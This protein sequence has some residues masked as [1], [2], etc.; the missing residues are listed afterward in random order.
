V[1]YDTL[2]FSNT[3]KG[4]L[5]VAPD[6]IVGRQR[7][8]DAVKR[9]LDDASLP[10]TLLIEGEAGIGKTTIWTEAARLAGADGRL[11]TARPSESE[12]KLSFSVLTD[13][14]APTLSEIRDALPVPQLRA[15]EL[16]LLLKAP[17]AGARLDARA[18]S[19]GTLGA[20]R[21]LA[22]RMPV[23]IAIDDVHW[24]DAASARSL[25]FA[26]R[27]LVNE[28]ITVVAARRVPGPREP[29]GLT[30]MATLRGL[31]LGPLPVDA[32]A[33]S[34][35]HVDGQFPR[36]LAKRI[37]EASGGNPFYALEIGRA[38]TRSSSSQPRAGEPLPVPDDL[39]S[40][41]RDRLNPLSADARDA[42]LVV[43][44]SPSPSADLVAA[45]TGS[46]VALEEA[47]R[48][49]I[50]TMS[51]TSVVFTHPLLASAVYADAAPS[52]RR[53]VHER[54]AAVSTDLEQRARHL[55]LSSTGPDEEA[56]SSLDRAAVQARARGAPQVAAELS[57]LALTATPPDDSVARQ[58]RMQTQAGNL[59]DAGDP[60]RAREIIEALIP[61]LE[62]GPARAE[63]LFMLSSF[64]WKDLRRVSELLHQAL[65]ETQ[66]ESL[67]SQILSDLAWV[68]LDMGELAIASDRA[69]A[70]VAV[71]ERLKDDAYPLRHALSILALTRDLLGDE[72]R[73]QLER[74]VALQGTL[75]LADLSSPTTCLG[76][77]LTWS[78]ELDAA[79]EALAS[80]LGRYRE[81]GHETACYEILAHLADV[82]HR[83]GRF[84]RA[85]RHLEEAEDIASEAGLDVLGE[86]LPVLAAVACSLGD[87]D[88]ASRHA[89]EGLGVC[90]RTADRWNEI[91]CRS[92]LGALE[93]SRD[94]AAAAHRWL[95][96][97][98]ELTEEMGLREPGAF[99]FVPDA[100]DA[101]VSL[102]ELDRATEL[103]DR[104]ERQGLDLGRPLAIGTAAR[105]RG[106][107]EAARGDLPAA[108]MWLERS[109]ET[110][111][112]LPHPFEVARTSL[113]AGEIKRRMKQ[114]SSAR[115]LLDAS[116]TGFDRIGARVWAAKARRA[117]TRIGGRP[118]APTDLSPSEEQVALL[119]A[120]GR[121]NREV[122]TSLFMSVHTVEANLKRI[123][124]KLDVRSR[125][126]LARKIGERPRA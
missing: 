57:E 13:L 120:E 66:G 49:E 64:A 7:E 62:P 63:A 61:R 80:E 24:M 52:T 17:V 67:R 55:A 94:D 71:A 16:A 111:R 69:Q 28:S 104:L 77:Q 79:R 22:A 93:I 72:S 73:D 126:E 43:A 82:E 102:G 3:P 78:G 6:T 106:S 54:L 23:T 36:P 87:L 53:G 96:T 39:H 108:A 65:A 51:G 90:E 125:V 15:L 100:V 27:R 10:R 116:V 31:H 42:L 45:V 114:K 85:L 38:L 5:I 74:A 113:V 60:R 76:R 83:A 121:S 12:A 37:H 50:V 89:S 1:P 124:R 19:L 112:G 21:S 75:T 47:A 44:A 99:P 109:Q 32:I 58:R 33:Q 48:A 56:A 117:L 20:L 9:F 88:D 4:T 98:P 14:F 86:I 119:V 11:L 35:H 70:A 29:I 41:L 2:L 95:G 92:V 91:R 107:I 103:T 123:Y 110:L 101:L 59:F 34:L 97:L 26:L 30:N 25:S 115:E 84:D 118:P 122:A 8:L 81:Q 18:V 46:D 68:G 105:C 40:L